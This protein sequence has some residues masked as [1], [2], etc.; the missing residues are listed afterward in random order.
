MRKLGAVVAGLSLAAFLAA[1]GNARMQSSTGDTCT[2]AG[3]GTAYTLHIAVR[4]G[5]QEFG[6][7][8]GTR[9][10]KVTNVAIPGMNGNFSTD[11]LAPNTTGAWIGDTPHAAH[12]GRLGCPERARIDQAPPAGD[13]R[14]GG[15]EI[16]Q[17]GDRLDAR[18]VLTFQRPR[19][20]APVA[21]ICA[22]PAQRRSSSSARHRGVPFHRHGAGR[23]R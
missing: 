19:F 10:V 18:E 5:G 23:R 2:S 22:P 21:R 9:G 14:L 1:T 17:Q 13:V 12:V 3:N 7:A 8:V 16:G 11:N 20:A 4:P 15:R 6:F